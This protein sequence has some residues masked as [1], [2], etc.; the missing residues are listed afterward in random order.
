GESSR[1][2]FRLFQT[3]Q[4]GTY[5]RLPNWE[6]NCTKGRG[7]RLRGC[8][9]IGRAINLPLQ[10]QGVASGKA[11]LV[12]IE[13][14]IDRFQ[15]LAPGIGASC[16]LAQLG[17]GIRA[18][19]CFFAGAVSTDVNEICCDLNRRLKACELIYAERGVVA[20][21]HL[22]NWQLMPT[23]IAELEGIAMSARQDLQ[24]LLEPFR[25]G[26]PTRR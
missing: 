26:I 17:P 7:S 4:S 23:R 15:T 18:L 24:Q 12:I 19:I 22:V 10:L 1:A 11:R 8:S 16:P 2:S 5:C 3:R 9:P 13:V 25:V 21:Q 14:E 20:A 6:E